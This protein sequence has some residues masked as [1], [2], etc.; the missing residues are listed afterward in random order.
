MDS[1][2]YVHV[3]SKLPWSPPTLILFLHVL[4]APPY[5]SP[6]VAVTGLSNGRWLPIKLLHQQVEEEVTANLLSLSDSVQDCPRNCHGN[7]ECVSGLC[8]CFPGFLG[9]DC[10][11]GT[12]LYFPAVVGKQNSGFSEGRGSEGRR[13]TGGEKGHLSGLP[14]NPTGASCKPMHARSPSPLA[15]NR[16]WFMT[17]GRHTYRSRAVIFGTKVCRGER[18]AENEMLGFPVNA[19]VNYHHSFLIIISFYVMED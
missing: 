13:E 15:K 7:G 5:W 8:H 11:K 4:N 12:C 14:P 18:F 19:E 3:L 10:A 1:G 16:A 6:E 9:A 2:G 17:I